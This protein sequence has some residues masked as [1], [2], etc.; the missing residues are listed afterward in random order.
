MQ[1][2]SLRLPIYVGRVS[3]FSSILVELA[4]KRKIDRVAL[5][6]CCIVKSCT[7]SHILRA[8]TP[9]V[10]LKYAGEVIASDQVGAGV[11]VCAAKV[12]G[13]DHVQ[14]EAVDISILVVEIQVAVIGQ[15]IAD[16][17]AEEFDIID[18]RW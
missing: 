15:P 8:F 12:G 18:N 2:L 10:E 1:G 6:T 9:D 3:S 17:S 11:V 14:S 5:K 16:D 7:Q 13:R 4:R